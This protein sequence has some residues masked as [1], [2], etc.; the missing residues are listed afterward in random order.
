M[1]VAASSVLAIT[2]L[3]GPGWL[4]LSR[5]ESIIAGGL[6]IPLATA[7]VASRILPVPGPGRLLSA[8]IGPGG[9]GGSTRRPAVQPDACV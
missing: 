5:R 8:M 9:R 2:A 1:S 6:A 7:R 3:A 4:D